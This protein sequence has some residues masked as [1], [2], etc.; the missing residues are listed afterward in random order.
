VW[1]VVPTRQARVTGVYGAHC[2]PLEIQVTFSWTGPPPMAAGPIG[3]A[4]VGALGA[5]GA[6]APARPGC[7]SSR[8]TGTLEARRG[9]LGRPPDHTGVPLVQPRARRGHGLLARARQRYIGTR[10]G[11][12]AFR[13]AGVTLPS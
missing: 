10:T 11:T 6:A 8:R 5:V 3:R 1:P 7:A 2:D 4:P 12:A 13:K 9:R